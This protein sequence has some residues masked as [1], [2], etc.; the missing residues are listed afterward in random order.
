MIFCRANIVDW[1]AV[2]RERNKLTK[3]SNKYENNTRIT[4]SYAAGDKILIVL[5]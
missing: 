4:K 1:K 3:A 5:E 2:H